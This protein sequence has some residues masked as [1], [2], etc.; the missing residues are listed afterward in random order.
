MFSCNCISNELLFHNN[1]INATNTT[2]TARSTTG[3]NIKIAKELIQ[4]KLKIR[5]TIEYIQSMTEN[6][7]YN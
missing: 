2:T 4:N 1:T 7:K 5:V 6:R 3:N